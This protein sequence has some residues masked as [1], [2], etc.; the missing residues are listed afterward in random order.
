VVVESA[1]A[2]GALRVLLAYDYPGNV[3]QLENLLEQAVVL[4]E[5]GL[6]SEADLPPEVGQQPQVVPVVDQ[7]LAT[8]EE[9]P[10]PTWAEAERA[11]LE[12]GLRRFGSKRSLALHLGIGRATLYRKLALYGLG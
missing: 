10:F 12:E 2:Q 1:L 9:R 6:I 4:D 5:D 3:R 8:G 11:L 7:P